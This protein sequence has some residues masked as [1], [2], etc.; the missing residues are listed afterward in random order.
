MIMHW[1]EDLFIKN[2]KIYSYV[3]E[4]IWDQGEQAAKAIADLLQEKGL[5]GGRV[6]DVPCGIGRVA[7]PLAKRGFE[8]IGVDF[9][10]YFINYARKK[11]RGRGVGSKASFMTGRMEHIDSLLGRKAFDCAIN[12]FT[13]IGYGS[14]KEDEAFFSALRHAV[15]KGGLF[16]IAQLVNR[17]YI[18]SHFVK[19]LYEE[20]RKVLVLHD[21]ELDVAH[22]RERSTWR[23]Y[24]NEGK[25]YKFVGESKIDLRLY[26]PHEIVTMLEEQ[27][28]K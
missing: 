28:G 19:N 5:R 20:F 26:S 3:L 2:A 21:N 18:A 1:A 6:I 13:S 17:D 4:S 22:S 15:R 24:L 8:V 10:P 27:V 14:E 11:A 23:F 7:I 12:I 25:S 9:S 16:I